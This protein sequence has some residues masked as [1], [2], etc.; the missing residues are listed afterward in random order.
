[1]TRLVNWYFSQPFTIACDRAPFWGPHNTQE[2]LFHRRGMIRAW[3]LALWWC[4]R[5][6]H[7]QARIIE[8][9]L[10]WEDSK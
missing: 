5:H 3:W 1:M 6:E 7:G 2:V 10:R 9:T 8:G 4:A